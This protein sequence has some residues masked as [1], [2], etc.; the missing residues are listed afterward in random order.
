MCNKYKFREVHW[1]CPL[2]PL[3]PEESIHATVAWW[4]EKDEGYT[5]GFTVNP[6]SA[7]FSHGKTRV[8]CA[9]VWQNLAL[10]RGLF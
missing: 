6:K 2:G 9:D 5:G 1:L 10:I 4:R 8:L 3:Q 7:P